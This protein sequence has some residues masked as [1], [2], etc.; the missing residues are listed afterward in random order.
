[1]RFF[2]LLGNFLIKNIFFINYTYIDNTHINGNQNNQS[3]IK[4]ELNKSSSDESIDDVPKDDEDYEGFKSDNDMRRVRNKK[5]R[6][7]TLNSDPDDVSDPEMFPFRSTKGKPKMESVIRFQTPK[8]TLNPIEILGNEEDRQKSNNKELFFSTILTKDMDSPKLNESHQNVR[9]N[10]ILFK[11]I[12]ETEEEAGQSFD[13]PQE[14]EDLRANKSKYPPIIEGLL[15]KVTINELTKEI[16]FHLVQSSG[17][18]RLLQHDTEPLT[19]KVFVTLNY[20]LVTIISCFT[21]QNNYRNWNNNILDY[22]VVQ[23]IEGLNS[24]IVHERRDFNLSFYK[25]RSF[26]YSRTMIPMLNMTRFLIIDKSVPESQS[27]GLGIWETLGIINYSIMAILPHPNNSKSHLLILWTQIDNQGLILT[28]NQN[29]DLTVKYL[30]QFAN[31]DNFL[32]HRSFSSHNSKQELF[33]RYTFLKSQTIFPENMKNNNNMGSQLFKEAKTQDYELLFE[34]I[35]DDHPQ[36]QSSTEKPMNEPSKN[37]SSV[38]EKSLMENPPHNEETIKEEEEESKS[39][40]VDK[41]LPKKPYSPLGL[42]SSATLLELLRTNQH[43]I[44]TLKHHYKLYPMNISEDQTHLQ[45]IDQENGGHYAINK[46]WSRAK[47]GGMLWYN[48]KELEVQGKVLTYLIKRLGSNLIQGKS[49]INISLPV[50]LFD[51]KSFLERIA[52]SYTYAPYFLEPHPKNLDPKSSDFERPGLYHIYQVVCFILSSLHMSISQ[53]KPFNPILGE[54]F[55]GWI[56]GCPI[57]CEQISHHPPISSFY[58]LGHHFKIQGNFEIAASMNPN[59]VTGKQ[60]GLGQVIFNERTENEK[61]IYFTFPPCVVSGLAFGSRVV[62]YEGKVWV[63]DAKERLAME[64]AFNPDKKGMISGLLSKQKTANDYFKGVV[65]EMK[66]AGIDKMMKGL[67]IKK[68]TGINFK[69]DVINNSEISVCEGIWH[70]YMEIKGKKYWERNDYIAYQ[71]EYEEKPLPSDCLYR[72]DL[73]VWR[74]HDLEEAQKTKEK[75]EVFQRNDKKL[76]EKVRGKNH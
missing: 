13:E 21:D 5:Q 47:E 4:P 43:T 8:G 38:I 2:Y 65:Y 26:H 68:Y 64:L 34:R 69:E 41:I 49:V 27:S 75:M 61:R 24:V 18:M 31:L 48:K 29:K 52:Y 19:F 40:S 58:M 57:S 15:G 16:G 22:K 28:K 53:K 9:N 63:F 30:S 44:Q 73:I 10:N 66:E 33:G 35:N 45:P 70:D 32:A 1:L 62:N 51:T 25:S 39:T 23:I 60:L 67:L 59:T 20:D 3:H 6:N 11:S 74:S 72:E 56:R 7:K 55:Q 50:D 71:L 42:Q 46:D 17:N 14:L 37:K 36:R 76:R 12:K 54:T